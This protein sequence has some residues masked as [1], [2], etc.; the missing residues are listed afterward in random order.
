[1]SK[2]SFLILKNET[3]DEVLDHFKRHVSDFSDHVEHLFCK[4]VLQDEVEILFAVEGF[5]ETYDIEKY[6]F[7]EDFLLDSDFFHFLLLS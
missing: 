3:G 1:M 4:D 2:A 7:L 5:D 6:R